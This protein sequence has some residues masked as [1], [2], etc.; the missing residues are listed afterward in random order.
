M[1]QMTLDPSFAK[2]IRKVFHVG[3]RIMAGIRELD[4]LCPDSDWRSKINTDT[5]D[6]GSRSQ[7][8]LGQI[9]GSYEAGYYI[10]RGGNPNERTPIKMGFNASVS[11]NRDDEFLALTRGWKIALV[12]EVPNLKHLRITI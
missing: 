12:H 9:F 4:L 2:D 6:I 7:G 10:I 11:E 3:G 5:L 8:V 1:H